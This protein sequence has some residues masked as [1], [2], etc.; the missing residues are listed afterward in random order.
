MTKSSLPLFFRQIANRVG[1]M[2]FI[3][4][5]QNP[6]DLEF[7][8]ADALCFVP[9]DFG[10]V[11]VAVCHADSRPTF[12]FAPIAG[13]VLLAKTCKVV[14]ASAFGNHLDVGY[15]AD[16]LEVHAALGLS[17][18]NRRHKSISSGTCVS[19]RGILIQACAP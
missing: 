7:L 19:Y 9:V 11:D 4:L 12:E 15:L 13:A 17:A 2:S 3:V 16:D 14:N 18:T 5:V 1:E 6:F 10:G 8:S